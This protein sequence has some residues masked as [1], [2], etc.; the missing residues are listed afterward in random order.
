MIDAVGATACHRAAQYGRLV[1]LQRLLRHPDL[2]IDAP[3]YSGQTPLHYAVEMGR[4]ACV[5]ALL[6]AGAA[7][8]AVTFGPNPQTASTIA[9]Q[10]WPRKAKLARIFALAVDAS[11]DSENT[12]AERDTYVGGDNMA[13]PSSAMGALARQRF[14]ARLV[15]QGD[16]VSLAAA[17]TAS[18]ETGSVLEVDMKIPMPAKR[19]SVSTLG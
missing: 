2:W 6:Q 16:D 4:T 17:L 12:S 5:A 9:V 18:N 15:E 3:T 11:N 8:D 19:S 10:N 14:V 7:K 13:P 1:V